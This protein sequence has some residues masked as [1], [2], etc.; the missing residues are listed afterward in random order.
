MNVSYIY[1]ERSL[2]I[3]LTKQ[4]EDSEKDVNTLSFGWKGRE[5]EYIFYWLIYTWNYVEGYIRN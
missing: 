5:K 4:K 2:N 1:M 3:L